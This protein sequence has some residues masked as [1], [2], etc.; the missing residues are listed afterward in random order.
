MDTRHALHQRQVAA[1][2]ILRNEL[3]STR[4][5]LHLLYAERAQLT[6]VRDPD[7]CTAATVTLPFQ[8]A[9]PE[10]R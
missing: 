2:R 6:L 5:R 3:P 7:A 9:L 10:A 4:A 8:P 1:G